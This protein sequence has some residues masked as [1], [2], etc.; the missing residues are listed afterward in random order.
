MLELW[1]PTFHA[2]KNLSERDLRD[3]AM[4]TT[5]FLL[6]RLAFQSG[7]MPL[8]F[9]LLGE[10]LAITGKLWKKQLTPSQS[11]EWN[12]LNTRCLEYHLINTRVV[13]QLCQTLCD[14]M[15]SSLWGSSVHGFSRQEYWNGLPFS[16][17]GDLPDPGIEPRSPALQAA[18]LPSKPPGKHKYKGRTKF[19]FC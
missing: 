5:L 11:T 2:V 13:T 12:M 19:Q 8:H 9:L 3:P 16:S 6:S 4:P 7:A 14:S 1:E 10:K 17:P 15:D 18:A